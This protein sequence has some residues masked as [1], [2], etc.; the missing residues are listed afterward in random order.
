MYKNFNFLHQ[1]SPCFGFDLE[2]DLP[3]R[4]CAGARVI[5]KIDK[6]SIAGNRKLGPLIT[7]AIVER[8]NDRLILISS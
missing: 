3:G 4:S 1:N 5:E 6:V 8:H 2:I 7:P